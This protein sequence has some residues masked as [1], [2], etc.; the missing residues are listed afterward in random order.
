MVNRGLLD[1]GLVKRSIKKGPKPNQLVKKIGHTFARYANPSIFSFF[2]LIAEVDVPSAFDRA[3]RYSVPQYQRNTFD[4]AVAGL[5]TDFLSF[6]VTGEVF[7]SK[8]ECKARLQGFA[9]SQGLQPS[10]ANLHKMGRPGEFL[11]IHHGTVTHNHRELED[12]VE[13]DS[14]GKVTSKRQRG[15]TRMMQKLDCGWRG[16]VSHRFLHGG[17]VDRIWIL[18]MTCAS[19]THVMKNPFAYQVHVKGTV[20]YQ[21]LIGICA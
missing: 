12:E 5:P 18:T 7:R 21:I 16:V 15:N 17:A 9:L 14:E 20:E 13:K 3:V 8:A 10:L 1:C 2:F 11:C 4:R 6:P 19:H